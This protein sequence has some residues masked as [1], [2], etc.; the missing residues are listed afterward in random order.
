MDLSILPFQIAPQKII[1]DIKALTHFII[2]FFLSYDWNFT[3]C[4]ACTAGVPITLSNLQLSPTLETDYD[5][6]ARVIVTL[7]IMVTKPDGFTER[8]S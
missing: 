3:I 5:I 1:S 8:A 6:S 7:P 2:I 4:L